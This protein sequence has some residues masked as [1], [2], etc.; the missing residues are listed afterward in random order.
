MSV[1]RCPTSHARSCSGSCGGWSIAGQEPA[2]QNSRTTPATRGMA[3]LAHVAVRLRST[4]IGSAGLPSSADPAS[5]R[6]P[7]VAFMSCPPDSLCWF[8]ACL[9]GKSCAGGE[10]CAEVVN[11]IPHLPSG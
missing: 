10:G 4:N 6:M 5:I 2:V 1:T 8:P 11:V 9:L 7:F 3:A